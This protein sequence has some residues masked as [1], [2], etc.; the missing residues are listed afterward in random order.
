MPTYAPLEVSFVKGEGVWLFDKENNKYLDALSGVGVTSLGHSH[1]NIV[2]AITTQAK[3]LIHTS[4]WYEIENQEKLAEKLSKL[5]K[6]DKV[7]FANSGAEANEVAI[8]LSRAY[9]NLKGIK[10]PIIITANKSFHGRTMATLS[11][12][13]N[14]N[15]QKKFT[16]LVSEFIYVDFNN[17]EELAKYNNN[18]NIVAVMLEPI[19]GESGVIIPNKNYLN[20]VRALCD[21]NSWLMILD[22][23]QTGIG[24]TGKWFAHQYNNIKPD[25]MTLA[26]ALGN[27]LPI[28]ACLATNKIANLFQA[29]NHG[30]TFGGNPLATATALAVIETIEKQKVLDNANTIGAYL[31]KKLKKSLKPFNFIK[32]IRG[33]GLMVAIELNI[34]CQTLLQLALDKKLLLNI[35]GQTIRLLP[36]LTL[37]KTEADKIVSIIVQLLKSL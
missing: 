3:Q 28:G 14:P 37:K 10:N 20:Q 25:I 31:I 9:A 17:I 30:S 8:K 5:S 24:R 36:P 23:V 19:Q 2:K 4:N 15:V 33:L 13:G 22:E 7:F 1:P 21:E 12:T 34:D 32:E 27:G 26:K 16:P 29:G 35:T 11:A 6:L 18:H